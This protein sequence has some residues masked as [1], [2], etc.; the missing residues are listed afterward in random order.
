MP[1]PPDHEVTF[2]YEDYDWTPNDG[3]T[4]PDGTYTAV[5]DRF[6]E[7]P[8][9]DDPPSAG[10]FV[11]DEDGETSERVGTALVVTRDVPELTPETAEEMAAF[12]TEL[13]DG[14]I[15]TMRYDAERTAALSF[16]PGDEAEPDGGTVTADSANEPAGAG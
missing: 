7:P 16:E 10:L 12:E 8:D 13:R 2:D 1:S 6:V 14:R 11:Y 4:P 9:P 3:E 15:E 5:F